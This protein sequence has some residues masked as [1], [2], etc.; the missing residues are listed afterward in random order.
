MSGVLVTEHRPLSGRGGFGLAV[1][2]VLRAAAIAATALLGGC[3]VFSFLPFVDDPAD[4]GKEGEPVPLEA[5]TA[6]ADI[7]RLWRTKVGRGLGRKVV[8]LAP[9]VVADRIYAA[10]GYGR[11]MALDRF[12]GRRVWSATIGKPDES[13]F[14]EFWDRR[15]PSFVTGGVGAAEG[16]ILL[17]T[18]R[19]EV[20]ALDAGDGTELWRRQLSSE[21][22]APPMGADGVVMTQTNDGRLVALE[23]EDGSTRWSF[24]NQVPLLSLRGTATPQ[25]ARGFVYA[26]FGDG[27]V[28]AMDAESGAMAW[29]H[30]IMLPQGRSELDRLVDV[31]GSPLFVPERGGV[32]FA[33]S[34]Q[35]RLKA[36]R[37]QDGGVLWDI[38][39]SSF[40]DLAEGYGQ[41]YVVSD[42][43]VVTAV[44]QA[45]AAIVWRQEGL[46]NRKLS[47]PTAFGNYVLVAD[48]EGFLHVL[49]QS[50]G[51]F[52]ARRKLGSGVR[53][54]MIEADNVVYVLGNDGNLDAL[55]IKRRG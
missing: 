48:S 7:E 35:G 3:A 16:R 54:R 2:A 30:R 4:E 28:I 46:M 22:L 24:D 40:L 41:V 15:D 21:V 17:G 37:G 25:L 50:D 8:R 20:V 36:L 29:E 44:Q 9:T 13:P 38:E 53:S 55:E 45:T 5:F 26:G 42:D 33:A 43:D 39:A 14:F 18:M 34:Y 31:D 6:E 10:D 19:G 51:R 1:T 47:S 11:V 23:A 32:L 12:N 49:A 52:V 27:R